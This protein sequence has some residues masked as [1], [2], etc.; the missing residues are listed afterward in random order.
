MR[1]RTIGT[2]HVSGLCIGGNPCSDFS[3][4]GPE[5]NQEMLDYHTPERIHE[6]LRTAGD[7]ASTPSS[8]AGSST[9]FRSCATLG[10]AA[11]K[12]S[13]S[14]RPASNAASRTPGARTTR[15]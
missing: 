13:G 15:T 11:A 3:H 2:A 1:L 4:Q 12:S 7:Q 14:P 5:R 8:A 6:V 10:P 9:S